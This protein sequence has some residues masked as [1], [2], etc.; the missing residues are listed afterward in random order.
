MVTHSPFRPFSSH[1]S[2]NWM[3]FAGPKTFD[4]NDDISTSGIDF[5]VKSSVCEI[6]RYILI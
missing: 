2:I 5:N 4:S 1:T 3:Y 6:V